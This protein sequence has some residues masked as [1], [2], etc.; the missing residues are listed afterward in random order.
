M[1]YFRFGDVVPLMMKGTWPSWPLARAAIFPWLTDV[2]LISSLLA[3][4]W[5]DARHMIIPLELT[6]AGF[7]IGFLLTTIAYPEFRGVD[8][9]LAAMAEAGKAVALGGGM[10]WLVRWI[11]GVVFKREAMGMGDIHLIIMLAMFM[12]W[13]EILLVIFLSALTGSVGGVIAKIIQRR[14]HWRFEIL[15]GPYIAA[16]AVITYFRGAQIIA[17]YM[18]FY[19][20]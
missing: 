18:R 11:G 16:G 7:V 3:I 5:I 14:T 10:L 17:W 15:Y 8:N 6:V 19:Q 1:F 4:I 13:T 9:P 2:T 12:N 20:V